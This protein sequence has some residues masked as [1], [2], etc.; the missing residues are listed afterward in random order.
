[1]EF[2]NSNSDSDTA[3]TTSI[4]TDSTDDDDNISMK[5]AMLLFS[6]SDT[7]CKLSFIQKNAKQ[8]NNIKQLKTVLDKHLQNIALKIGC[9]MDICEILTSNVR[10][11]N[12]PQIR[13]KIWSYID[14]CEN[15]YKDNNSSNVDSNSNGGVFLL[16]LNW[17]VPD[18]CF[19]FTLSDILMVK[20]QDREFK[21]IISMLNA[22]V[23]SSG[24]NSNVNNGT[25]PIILQHS[26]YLHDTF[27]KANQLFGDDMVCLILFNFVL[28]YLGFCVVPIVFNL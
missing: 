12:V 6:D 21:S 3:E 26:K 16:G 19:T 25:L 4:K 7:I 9:F 23:E 5:L 1:M 8:G 11:L 28:F 2:K 15:N 27:E 13:I 24:N 17:T 10:S 22:Y 14:E 18:F 20:K